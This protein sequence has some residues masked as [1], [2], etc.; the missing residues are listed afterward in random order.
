MVAEIISH[1]DLKLFTIIVLVGYCW[2]LV[3]NP[4]K[5]NSV[6]V[7]FSVAFLTSFTIVNEVIDL[8]YS[9]R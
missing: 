2:F 4:E 9:I 8:I 7:K 1:I 6:F 3:N 5:I